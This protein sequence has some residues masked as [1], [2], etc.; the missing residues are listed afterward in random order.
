[1]TIE[2]I[3]QVDI[4]VVSISLDNTDTDDDWLP[5]WRPYSMHQTGTLLARR[6]DMRWENGELVRLTVTGPRLR[7]NGER[8]KQDTTTHYVWNT[9]TIQAVPVWLQH[10]VVENAPEDA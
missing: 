10:L 4:R 9:R 6:A 1:M 2:I 3:K 8:G 5:I 7:I